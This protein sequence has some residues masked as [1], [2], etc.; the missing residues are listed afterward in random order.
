MKTSHIL[1]VALFLIAASCGGTDDRRA[2]Q[3]SVGQALG[4]STVV[5]AVAQHNI[6]S[7]LSGAAVQDA[8]LKNAW[9]LAFN[10]KGIAWVNANGSGIAEVLKADGSKAIPSV[11]IPPPA[12]GT[13]PSAPT[14]MVFNAD[15][16]KFKGDVFIMVTEDGTIAGWQPGQGAVLRADNS[17]A[18]AVYKGATIASGADGKPRLYAANFRQGTVEVYDDGYN[19]I[20]T[21]GGFADANIPAGFAPFNVQEI[22][23]S[24]VAT[25]AKQDDAKHDDVKGPGNGF[26]DQYDADGTLMTRLISGGAL[27]SPWGLAEAPAGFGSLGG[28]VLVGNFGD[29][30]IN[31]YSFTTTPHEGVHLAQQG[32][33][34]D[35]NGNPVVIDGLWA[36]RFGVDAGGFS[37]TTLYFTAGPNGEADGVFGELVAVTTPPPPPS[38]G[39]TP[40]PSDGGTPPPSDGGARAW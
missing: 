27:N 10:P 4:G 26:V 29:G 6:V 25:Y 19:R 39:G 7:D 38:D 40:P 2:S 28:S 9:G 3:A 37:S 17:T 22:N 8:D 30:R 35:A 1:G 12:G 13:P 16:S 33:L 5:Q 36:L 14:G 23:G 20:T 31:V 24:V 32:V 18:N 34:G 15:T 11:T 21:K